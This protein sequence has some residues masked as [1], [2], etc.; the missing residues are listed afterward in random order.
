MLA[1]AMR[2]RREVAVRLALDVSRRRLLG[3]SLTE[4]LI[5]AGLG[6]CQQSAADL[7]T[8]GSV[9]GMPLAVALLASALPAL[10]A[11]RADPNAALRA[12]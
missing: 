9:A 8:H 10:R 11:T 3:Q 5:L 2:R 7:S 1:R 4:S 6:G 12:D